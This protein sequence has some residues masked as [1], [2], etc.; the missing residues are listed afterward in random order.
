MLCV[1]IACCLD[2]VCALLTHLAR[3][4]R[5]AATRCGVTGHSMGAYDECAYSNA[6]WSAAI[7]AQPAATQRHCEFIRA[8]DLYP[9]LNLVAW[10]VTHFGLQE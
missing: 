10:F 6:A 4:P 8:I 9:L 7:A 3:D 2:D 1:V 5:V